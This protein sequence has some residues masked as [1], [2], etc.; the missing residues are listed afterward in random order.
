MTGPKL[1]RTQFIKETRK[2]LRKLEAKEFGY[3]DFESGSISCGKDYA[4]VDV[5]VNDE[6]KISAKLYG[7]T[8]SDYV[9]DDNVA[10][11]VDLTYGKYTENLIEITQKYVSMCADHPEFS[12]ID[13]IEW[14]QTLV[15]LANGYEEYATTV[16]KGHYD[17]LDDIEKW[18]YKKILE[19]AKSKLVFE[20][21]EWH[22]RG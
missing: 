5:N 2:L 7:T 15:E 6:I 21:G 19:Y 22:V 17:Y 20:G 14:K 3:V 10:V 1:N 18:A 16:D 13:S 11:D 8:G 9:E 4:H 12:E